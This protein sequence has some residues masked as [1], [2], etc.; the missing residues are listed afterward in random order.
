MTN[1]SPMGAPKLVKFPLDDDRAGI[2]RKFELFGNEEEVYKGYFTINTYADGTPGELVISMNKIGGF[3]HGFSTAW[4]IAVS[5]LLQ[6]GVDPREIYAKF[7]FMEFEPSGI[8]GVPSVPMAKSLI[9]LIMKF[10]EVNFPPTGSRKK[11]ELDE[12]ET[13]INSMSTEE[14]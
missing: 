5:L 12:Y 3:E 1:P 13:A 9:D 14:K 11:E 8:T 10:M 6:Y 7:K 2:T 4:A